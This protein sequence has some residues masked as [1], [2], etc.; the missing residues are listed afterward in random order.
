MKKI[1]LS[2]L[3]A[4][5]LVAT[6]AAAETYEVQFIWRGNDAQVGHVTHVFHDRGFTMV[7]Q[8]GFVRSYHQTGRRVY[9]DDLG[10]LWLYNPAG[11]DGIQ[12]IHAGT[13]NDITCYPL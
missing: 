4:T 1:L 5:P 12:L 9:K 6:P 13:G 2:L 11:R 10:Q 8:D 7:W 3:A